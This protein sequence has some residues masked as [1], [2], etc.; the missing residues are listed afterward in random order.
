MAARS[1]I[2]IFVDTFAL[3]VLSSMNFDYITIQSPGDLSSAAA[4]QLL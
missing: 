4:K 1:P 2:Y 3:V